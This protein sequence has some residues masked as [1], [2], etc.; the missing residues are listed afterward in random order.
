MVFQVSD[1]DE[2]QAPLLDHLIEL[3][4]R[5]LRAIAALAVAFCVCLYFASDIFGFLIR[6]LT[7]AFPPGLPTSS[8]LSLP[9]DSTP[10]KRKHSCRSCS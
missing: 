5:L 9:R 3:R 2:S 10:R 1:I 7:E 8:G 6:P 4:T